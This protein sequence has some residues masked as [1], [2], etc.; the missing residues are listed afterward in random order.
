M[1]LEYMEHLEYLWLTI[2][3]M[4]TLGAGAILVHTVLMPS[5]E[6]VKE[7][8]VTAVTPIHHEPN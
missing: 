7:P 1:S 8:D 4:A 2:S 3:I 5:T 6:L